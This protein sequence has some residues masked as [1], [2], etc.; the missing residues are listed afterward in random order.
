MQI[1]TS[2]LTIFLVVFRRD[3][4]GMLNIALG[5]LSCVITIHAQNED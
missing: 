1:N 4:L 3:E 2:H 5:M